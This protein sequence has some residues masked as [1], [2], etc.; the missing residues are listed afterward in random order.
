MGAPAQRQCRARALSGAG[1]PRVRNAAR[2]PPAPGSA[3]RALPVPP[4]QS[5]GGLRP[6]HRPL[7][8]QYPVSRGTPAEQRQLRRRAP[9]LP[10][11]A[12]RPAVPGLRPAGP[13]AA[14]ADLRRPCGTGAGARIRH[15]AHSAR[16]GHNGSPTGAGQA[17]GAVGVC[18]ADAA[19]GPADAR[20]PGHRRPG[21]MATVAAARCRLCTLAAALVAGS[22]A[23]VGPARAQP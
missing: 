14:A 1:Q 13:G 2:S 17:A 16:P 8:R 22:R 18:P 12:L 15:P 20:G 19:A 6:G 3:L 23:A 21:R 5:A 11:A 4:A 10:A 7:H 9:V